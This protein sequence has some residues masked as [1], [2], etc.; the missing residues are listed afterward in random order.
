[1]KTKFKRWLFILG[2]MV[3][4][5]GAIAYPPAPHHTFQ[6]ML[7]DEY[8]RPIPN[9]KVTVHF[10]NSSGSVVTS[11]A[12]KIILP[13]VNYQIEVPMDAGTTR[14]LYKPFAMKTHMPFKISVKVGIRI[15]LPMEMIGNIN[16]IGQPGGI[17]R[18]DLTLGEDSDGD[19]LPDAWE[20]ALLGNGRALGD[21]N[22]NDDTDGDGLTNLQEYISGNYAFDKEDGFRLDIVETSDAGV[23]LE[24]LAITGRTYVVEQSNDLRNWE[25]VNFTTRDD[26]DTPQGSLV[27]GKV[28]RVNLTVPSSGASGN[29]KFFKLM[30]Q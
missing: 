29:A 16:T 7:R 1:M 20:R 15:Y 13:G 21:I 19:G 10:E 22:P 30:V 24:F 23:K 12:G 27:A 9:E 3:P 28:T 8:G 14:Q 6:G 17:T 2:L 4:A 5:A 11:K 26:Q 18:L 25:L